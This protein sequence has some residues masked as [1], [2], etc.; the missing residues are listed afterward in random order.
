M[1]SAKKEEDITAHKT[2]RNLKSNEFSR[3]SADLPLKFRPIYR[4]EGSQASAIQ[5][6]NPQEDEEPLNQEPTCVATFQI[7]TV[8]LDTPHRPRVMRLFKK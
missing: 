8:A 1:R 2:I 5:N 3:S 6:L 4:A 7:R